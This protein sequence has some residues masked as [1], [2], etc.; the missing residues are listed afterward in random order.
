MTYRCERCG[1]FFTE[2]DIY[3]ASKNLDGENGWETRC[4]ETCPWCGCEDYEKEVFEKI[5]IESII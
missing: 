4:V 1:A 5:K 2:L 3:T